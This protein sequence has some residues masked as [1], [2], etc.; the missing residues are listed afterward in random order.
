MI[1]YNFVYRNITR[2][3]FQ[4]NRQQ[5]KENVTNRNKELFRTIGGNKN[6]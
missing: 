4:T 1:S 3:I 2:N 6:G 5:A